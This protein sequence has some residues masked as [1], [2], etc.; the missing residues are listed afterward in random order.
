MLPAMVAVIVPCL[1]IRILLAGFL[2]WIG[3]VLGLVLA[4]I[5]AATRWT[6]P[7]TARPSW[8]AWD[9]EDY[10][11]GL[12]GVCARVVKPID[13]LGARTVSRLWPDPG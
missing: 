13:E 3:I 4:V 6:L 2:I 12:I 10:L 7:S 8:S 9:G 11:E 5:A 1:A